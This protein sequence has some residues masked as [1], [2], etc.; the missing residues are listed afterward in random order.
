MDKKTL[1][2][3]I[4][5]KR[6]SISKDMLITKS[7]LIAKHLFNTDFYKASKYIMTYIDF[8]NEVKTEEIIKKSLA[9]EKNII[10]PISVVKTRE[11]IL[12]KL[13]DYDN[14]LEAGTYGI[15]EPKPQFIRK[16]AHKVIDLVLIP[17]VAFDKRGF[18][19]GYGAGYY[20]RFL[21]KLDKSVPKVALAFDLQLVSHVEEG[22]YDIAVDYIIT[23]SGIIRCK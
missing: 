10:I 21:K 20:D 1:R 3:E 19:I 11:L 22:K 12:S 13:L 7:D 16:V 15:L 5:L 9:Y 23:E 18:R 2:K 17:G 14:E 8:R 6:S 4:L